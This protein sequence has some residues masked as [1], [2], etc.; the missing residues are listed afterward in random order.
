MTLPGESA[1][2]ER[3]GRLEKKPAGFLRVISPLPLGH[4]LKNSLFLGF[5]Q[6]WYAI[7]AYQTPPV[8][9][10]LEQVMHRYHNAQGWA[11]GV[12]TVTKGQGEL[13]KV[14]IFDVSNIKEMR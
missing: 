9:I 12:F 10:Y 8:R 7:S 14:A 2:P 1:V 13:E 3:S 5:S 6:F 4:N 11:M